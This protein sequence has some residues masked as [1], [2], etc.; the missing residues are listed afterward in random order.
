MKELL[1]KEIDR[2]VDE[3][4]WNDNK[5]LFRTELEYLVTLAE[6]EQIKELIDNNLTK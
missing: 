6:R 1:T 4:P 3:Y 2:I 5:E